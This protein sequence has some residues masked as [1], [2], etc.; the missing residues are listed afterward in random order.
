MYIHI[1]KHKYALWYR[2]SWRATYCSVLLAVCCSQYVAPRATYM[3]KHIHLREQHIALVSAAV[4]L[5]ECVCSS[6]FAAVCLQQCVCS[7]FHCSM[8][9][10]EQ[11]TTNNY[12]TKFSRS[13]HI[14]LVSAA[15]SCVDVS[16]AVSAAVSCTR[17]R[18]SGIVLLTD[19]HRASSTL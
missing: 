2:P 18:V 6:V 5:Q 17:L 15:V 19:Q 11:H 14:P 16:I 3:Y 8:L 1:Y 12:I 7:R 13:Q 10:M 4:C 9:L